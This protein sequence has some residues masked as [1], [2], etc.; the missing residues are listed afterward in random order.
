MRGGKNDFSDQFFFFFVMS[1]PFPTYDSFKRAF[2]Y[3][4][5]AED[6]GFYQR[7]ITT[8]TYKVMVHQYDSYS[9]HRQKP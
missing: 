1:L 8:E 4:D 5:W 3:D 9:W 7:E 6:S 2:G